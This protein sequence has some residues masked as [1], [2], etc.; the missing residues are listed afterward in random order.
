MLESLSLSKKVGKSSKPNFD[1]LY[2]VAEDQAGYF[3][4]R[5]AREAGYSWERLVYY[6]EIGRFKRI[7]HGIYRLVHFPSSPFEDLFIAWLRTGPDSVISHE[8]AL[9]VYDLSDMLPNI[10]HVIV[11]RTASRRRKGLKQHTNRLSPDEI[12]QREGLPIT[13]VERTIADVA[14][15]GIPEE[16]V[17]QAIREALLRGMTNRLRLLSHAQ[18]R[19]GRAKKLIFKALE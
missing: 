17:N 12:T 15:Y 13:T 2:S 16:F 8:S 14:D 7:A 9:S 6:K 3:T 5:Q 10:I 18:R 19:R 11:P 4:A 1:H